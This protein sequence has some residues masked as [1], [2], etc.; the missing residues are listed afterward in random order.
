MSAKC[1]LR[2]RRSLRD[3]C[4]ASR[5]A[6]DGR[7]GSFTPSNARS[8]A[9]WECRVRYTRHEVTARRAG[10]PSGRTLALGGAPRLGHVFG[11][12]L[13]E[14]RAALVVAGAEDGRGVNGGDDLIGVRGGEDL[15][16]VAHEAE[17]AAEEAL[18]GGGPEAQDDAGF[19]GVDLG[20]EPRAAGRDLGHAGVLVEA[21][22]A[23][24]DE[25]EVLDGVGEVDRRAVDV[26]VGE[27]LIEDAAGGADEGQALQVFLV[28]GL[29]AD[30][31][32]GGGLVEVDERRG[33]AGHDL[34]G[35][36]VEV[37]PLAGGE[38]G[39][40]G[41]EGVVGRDEGLGGRLGLLAGDH[42]VDAGLGFGDEVGEE[43]DFG[44]V[45]PVADGHLGL[46]GD[47]VEA[48]G[49]EDAAVVGAPEVFELVFGGG[50][51][52]RE[53]GAEGDLTGDRVPGGGGVGGDDRPAHD[54][55]AIG[56]EGGGEREDAVVGGVPGD[57]VFAIG[58]GLVGGRLAEMDVRLD[59]AEGGGGLEDEVVGLV[60]GGIGA[61]GDQ[62]GLIDDHRAAFGVDRL[63]GLEDLAEADE[64]VH[65]VEVAPD[66]GLEAEE[67]GDVVIGL[68]AKEIAV[69][70]QAVEDA[71]QE[72]PAV[73][74]AV[75]GDDGGGFEEGL[76]DVRRG[77][78]R[79]GGLGF[80]LEGQGEG[81]VDGGVLEVDVLREIAGV[82][83]GAGVGAPV[84]EVGLDEEVAHGL[85]RLGCGCHEISERVYGTKRAEPF[86]C[87]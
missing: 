13:A 67:L 15:A 69:G 28:A 54:G 26:E 72:V 86:A 34:G 49:V 65:F 53:A 66:L 32:E 47:R 73:G 78:G 64:G 41:R 42:G 50:G 22:L 76:G 46:H 57:E 2:G 52:T 60:G 21:E 56:E 83:E 4:W 45:L 9:G 84:G 85:A 77:D 37:A 81:G 18:G 23:A 68:D 7:R 59:G 5:G 11:E 3:V 39:V 6:T 1:A 27:D 8:R 36:A 48:G 40:D 79:A 14:L 35:V 12:E 63:A 43:R 87:G 82:K 55:E 16:V 19:D 38:G 75:D 58:V 24:L 31:H 51:L 70:L 71:V 10:G 44:E 33:D 25:L 74:A 29:L 20:L 62:N 80:G 30:E 17:G 61:G